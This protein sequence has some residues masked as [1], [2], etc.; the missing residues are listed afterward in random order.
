MSLTDAQ[1]YVAAAVRQVDT[2]ARSLER[3]AERLRRLAE[4]YEMAGNARGG[5][6]GVAA[7]VVNEYTQSIGGNGTYLWGVIRDAQELDA[8]FRAGEGK[9]GS[10]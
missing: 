9:G 5:A 10:E 2:V 3:L 6:V 8:F 4:R 7:E 1:I